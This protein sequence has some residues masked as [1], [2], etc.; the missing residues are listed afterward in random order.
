MTGLVSP[1]RWLTVKETA[2][3]LGLHE[4]TVRRKIAAGDVP[5]MQLGGRG[6]A[7][8]VLEDELERWLFRPASN[9]V[10]TTEHREQH[11]GLQGDA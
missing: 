9:S 4:I 3:R 11:D 7:L 5:A 8:R 2:R 1:P 10:S 6:C